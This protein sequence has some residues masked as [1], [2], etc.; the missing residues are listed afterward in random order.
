VGEAGILLNVSVL[1]VPTPQSLSAWTDTTPLVKA[2]AFTDTVMELV[3]E[4]PLNPEG[5]VH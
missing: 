5:N 2:D 1:A 3:D 4:V